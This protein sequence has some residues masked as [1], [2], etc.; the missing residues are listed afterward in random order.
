MKTTLQ[1]C[2]YGN[3]KGKLY[4]V[5]AKSPRGPKVLPLVVDF[6]TESLP[7]RYYFDK[8]GGSP[9]TTIYH[10]NTHVVVESKTLLSKL[11]EFLNEAIPICVKSH[12]SLR[13][14][15]YVGV[16]VRHKRMV[17]QQLGPVDQ[18]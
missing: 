12:P 3:K 1:N 5:E 8:V 18:R 10:Y 6:G 17:F 15:F 4:F 13:E 7:E 16:I 2:I 11:Y 9:I 14:F